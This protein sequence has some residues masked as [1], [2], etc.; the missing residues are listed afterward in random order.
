MFCFTWFRSN[1]VHIYIILKIYL[2]S[3]EQVDL[4][5][6]VLCTWLSFGSDVDKSPCHAVICM[7][8]HYSHSEKYTDLEQVYL[9]SCDSGWNCNQTLHNCWESNPQSQMCDWH[10]ALLNNHCGTWSFTLNA[11]FLTIHNPLIDNTLSVFSRFSLSTFT[12]LFDN[13][14]K[15]FNNV[16]LLKKLRIFLIMAYVKECQ[17]LFLWWVTLSGVG[18]NKMAK[19]GTLGHIATYYKGL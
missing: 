14:C 19:L 2:F 1:F 16:M 9:P 8:C 7:L 10:N 12:T 5:G 15:I 17:A 13:L 4:L 18:Q 3:L 11:Q 6:I